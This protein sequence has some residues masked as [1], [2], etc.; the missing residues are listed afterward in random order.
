DATIQGSKDV[1]LLNF[2]V[3]FYWDYMP[4]VWLLL[5]MTGSNGNNVGDNVVKAVFPS[6]ALNIG[7]TRNLPDYGLFREIKA[8]AAAEEAAQAER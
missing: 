1:C 7:D 4:T 5:V 8:A 3:F 6:R 2:G